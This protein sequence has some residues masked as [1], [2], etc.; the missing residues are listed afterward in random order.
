MRPRIGVALVLVVLLVSPWPAVAQ[1]RSWDVAGQTGGWW[2]HPRGESGTPFIDDDWFGAWLGSVTVG[3]YWTTHIKTELDATFTS[4]ATRYIAYQVLIP[5]ERTPRF[6]T[7]DERRSERSVAALVTLQAGRNW[8]VHPFVQGGVSMDWDRVR[9]HVFP[10][11]YYEGTPPGG[12][13]IELT[14]ERRLGPHT[15]AITRAVVAGGAK[16]YV[17]ERWF[18]RADLRTTFGGDAQQVLFRTGF[19]IDF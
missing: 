3:R 13:Y 12:R 2:G 7:A 14:P 11:G 9:S 16:F 4:E 6:Y 18:F 1:Q 19:G 15:R 17:N 10:Q 8:W 5:G